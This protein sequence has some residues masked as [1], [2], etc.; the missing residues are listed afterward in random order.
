M[1]DVNRVGLDHVKRKLLDGKRDP[2]DDSEPVQGNLR[3]LDPFNV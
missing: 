2:W 3:L 1:H